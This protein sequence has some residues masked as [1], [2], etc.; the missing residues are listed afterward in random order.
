VTELWVSCPTCLRPSL[1]C[2]LRRAWARPGPPALLISESRGSWNRFGQIKPR[3]LFTANGYW[4]K[5]KSLDSLERIS[6]ILKQ[7]PSIEKVVVVPYTE[8]NPRSAE[9]QKAIAYKDF[10]SSQGNL[11]MDFVQLP[12]DYPLYIMYSSGTTGLPKCMVQSAG[13]VLINQLKELLLHTDLK[14]EDTIFYFTTCGWMMW[15]WLTCSLAVGATLM[16]YDGFPF[17]PQ[18]GGSGRWRRITRSRFSGR[19]RATLPRSWPQA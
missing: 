9:F 7:L 4:F 10:R 8:R 3:V 16:L 17:H 2:S 19:A 12:F 1:P 5:G 11:G 15:N 14:R 13:G 6:D 18:A